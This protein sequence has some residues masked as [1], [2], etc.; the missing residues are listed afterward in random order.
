MDSN[1][2]S[3]L[4]DLRSGKRSE[5]DFINLA[6]AKEGERMG[7]SAPVNQVLG[8]MLKFFEEARTNNTLTREVTREMLTGMESITNQTLVQS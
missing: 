3:M 2:P 6:V 8:L 5:I 7:L 4:Q 1:E